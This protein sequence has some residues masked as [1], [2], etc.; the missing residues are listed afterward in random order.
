MTTRKTPNTLRRYCYDEMCKARDSALTPLSKAWHKYEEMGGDNRDELD[1]A[2]AALVTAYTAINV[3]ELYRLAEANRRRQAQANRKLGA[4]QRSK[5]YKLGPTRPP[6]EITNSSIMVP[7][8]D[9]H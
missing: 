3:E 2:V 7:R 9:R 5:A 1:N 6:R 8:W 4:G